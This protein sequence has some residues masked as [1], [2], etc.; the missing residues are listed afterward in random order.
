MKEYKFENMTVGNILEDKAK[1]M[2]KRI[3]KVFAM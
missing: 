3:V 2:D 1:T